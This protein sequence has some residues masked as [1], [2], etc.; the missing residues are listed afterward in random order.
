M[1]KKKK[2][3]KKN[4]G[5]YRENRCKILEIPYDP[6]AAIDFLSAVANNNS[7]AKWF[8]NVAKLNY[9]REN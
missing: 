5:K 6:L 3:N 8:A 1:K 9:V 7:A 2:K 4:A